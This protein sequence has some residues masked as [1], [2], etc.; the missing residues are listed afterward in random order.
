MKSRTLTYLKA[1]LF[2]VLAVRTRKVADDRKAR[3]TVKSSE[4]QANVTSGGTPHFIPLWTTTTNLGSSVIFQDAASDNIG[5][6]TL[7]PQSTLDVRTND[8]NGTAIIGVS[9]NTSGD[10]SNAGVQGVC[11]SPLATGVSGVAASPSGSTIGVGGVTKSPAGIGMLGVGVQASKYVT[12]PG[13][14]PIGVWGDT[15]QSGGIGVIGTANDGYGVVAVNNSPIHETLGARNDESVNPK[16]PVF[17]ALGNFFGGKCII[18]TLGNLKCNGFK[19]A[20][21]PLADGR[22]VTL[23]A[24]EAPENWFEDVGSGK[25]TSG[26]ATVS[27]DS[28]FAETVNTATECHVFLTPKG[29]CEGLY[30][31]N[32]T[33]QGF[34]VRELRGGRSS[35]S[36]DYRV[37]ARRKGYENMRLEDVTEQF[38]EPQIALDANAP[39][40]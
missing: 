26:M 24:V 36:F 23:Y 30:V 22:K 20:V 5:I 13:A 31:A 12:G 7:S 16:S 4:S 11:F 37:M 6:G 38:R 3:S 8:P 19:A 17:V 27:L 2:A 21:V 25:L 15:N 35:V 39:P 28:T 34:E 33:P 18:D 32:E 29:E 40:H 1:S 14:R 10:G 9:A